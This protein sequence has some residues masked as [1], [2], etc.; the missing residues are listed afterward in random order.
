MKYLF[1]LRLLTVLVVLL[2]ISLLYQLSPILHLDRRE[3]ECGT[4]IFKSKSEVSAEDWDESVT[5]PNTENPYRSTKGWATF[6][7]ALKRYK[8][9]HKDKLERLKSAQR[10][11]SVRTL[12]WACSQTRCSGLG[13]QL[14]RL[15]FFFLLAM[16]SDRTF[17]IYWDE[18]CRRVPS[19]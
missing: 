19:I 8:Q 16:M 14:L 15:Q 17:T 5:C 13:D 18:G 4:E 12:T 10:N 9:F 6:T 7:S 1:A 2:I 11:E 3:T